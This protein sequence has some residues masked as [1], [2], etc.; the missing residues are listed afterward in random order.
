MLASAI[1]MQ[2]KLHS[3]IIYGSG[4]EGDKLQEQKVLQTEAGRPGLSL[5]RKEGVAAENVPG[6][7]RPTRGPLIL[8]NPPLPM[9]SL[10]A[11]D[12]VPFLCWGPSCRPLWALLIGRLLW[13]HHPRGSVR[14]E[15]LIQIPLTPR[16]TDSR[17]L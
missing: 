12:L 13:C 6:D 8:L 11:L 15:R 7:V 5:Q 1:G 4:S 9:R 17:Q 10:V 16:G 2:E 3:D 14:L